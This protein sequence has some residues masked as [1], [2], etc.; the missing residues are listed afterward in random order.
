MAEDPY[1]KPRQNVRCNL[2]QMAPQ[3]QKNLNSTQDSC[4]KY[5]GAF[6]REVFIHNSS[7]ICPCQTLQVLGKENA[8]NGTCHKLPKTRKST[9]RV[10]SA[11][12]II[13]KREM[14]FTRASRLTDVWLFITPMRIPTRRPGILNR[15]Y[16]GQRSLSE[17][18]L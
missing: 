9:P 4:L 1:I 12:V 13:G 5:E 14:D 15:Q 16:P 3:D 2:G 17:E 6:S 7:T 10:F 8:S 11:N 18:P